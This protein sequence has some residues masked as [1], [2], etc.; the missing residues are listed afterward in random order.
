MLRTDGIVG[1]AVSVNSGG[2]VATSWPQQMK[3]KLL[4]P[5]EVVAAEA[6]SMQAREADSAR[7][8]EIAELYQAILHTFAK[9]AALERGQRE[10]EVARARAEDAWRKVGLSPFEAQRRVSV[11]REP[12]FEIVGA[13]AYRWMKPILTNLRAAR[14][15]FTMWWEL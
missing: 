11:Q 2:S 14:N 3:V 9:L 8:S 5:Q 4:D 6:L 10:V 7:A 1:A 12:P 13:H 15:D